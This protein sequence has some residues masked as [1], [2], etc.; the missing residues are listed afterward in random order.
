MAGT[1]K[2]RKPKTSKA[3][4]VSKE[5]KTTP[6][7]HVYSFNQVSDLGKNYAA[8]E[9]QVLKQNRPFFL[10]KH[11]NGCGACEYFKARVYEPQREKGEP[12][13]VNL[14]KQLSSIIPVIEMEYYVYDHLVS[15]HPELPLAQLTKDTPNVFPTFTIIVPKKGGYDS[16]LDYEGSRE[17][18]AM[19]EYVKRVLQA[20]R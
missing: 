3:V 6:K 12:D 9:K 16:S 4:K 19:L 10:F 14:K 2:S 11:L 13:P 18:E 1:K 17:P 15:A 8:F 7:T 5:P 20:T